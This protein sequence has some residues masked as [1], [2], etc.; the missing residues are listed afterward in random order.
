MGGSNTTSTSSTGSTDPQVQATLDPLLQGVQAAQT[1]GPQVFNQSLYAG[2]G[3]TTTGA[4]TSA[5]AAANNPDYASGVN[6]AIGANNSLISNGGLNTGE[7]GNLTSAN[8]LASQYGAM[9]LDPA[10]TQ[11]GRNLINSITTGTN[12]SF[13]NSGLFGS[14][15]NQTATALGLTQGLGNL[16]Q[17]Y[18]AGQG[19]ALQN[20][21]GMGQQGIS[22]QQAAAAALPGLYSAAQAPAATAGAVGSAQD[23]N[24]QAALL[25]QND[26]FQRNAQ[27]PTD[28]LAKLSAILQGG[29]QTAGTTTTSTTPTTPWYQ[30]LLGMGVKTA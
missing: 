23:A 22:N 10:S 2:V 9:A 21:F 6:G 5:L 16:Q 18:M 30:S 8:N 27:A 12:S 26:L 14:D 20:A 25:G 3:P 24:S 11:A 13:N 7:Q 29:A 1:K 19:T 28:L 15:N 17:G 4:W